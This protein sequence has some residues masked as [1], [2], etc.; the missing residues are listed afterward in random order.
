M[1]KFA[2]PF[3]VSIVFFAT[4]A[5]IPTSVF[6][7]FSLLSI[8]CEIFS[9]FLLN[10][11]LIA[12]ISLFPPLFLL[13]GVVTLAFTVGLSVRLSTAATILPMGDSLGIIASGPC[14]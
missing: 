13:A 6:K 5:L 1:L 10:S 9:K 8:I 14:T 4:V 2:S 3:L 12:V 7:C 11:E